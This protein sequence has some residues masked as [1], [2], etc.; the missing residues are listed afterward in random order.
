MENVFNRTEYSYTPFSKIYS[1]NGD[2]T[3]LCQAHTTL[4]ANTP[5]KV[6]KNRYGYITVAATDAAQ[7]YFIGV[8]DKPGLGIEIDMAQIELAHQ[9]YKSMGLS[10]RDDSVAMQY[11]IPNWKFDPKRPSLVR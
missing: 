3:V 6:I 8:P 1:Q 7:I 5:Y 4:T 11:L 9:R 2:V 10:G